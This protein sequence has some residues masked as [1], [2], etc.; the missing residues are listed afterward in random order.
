M[1]CY[2][3]KS[4]AWYELI[5]LNI[6]FPWK[7]ALFCYNQ[8][9]S[10]LSCS[11]SAF[12][13]YHYFLLY[14]YFY[15]RNTYSTALMLSLVRSVWHLDVFNLILKLHYSRELNVAGFNFVWELSGV[16]YHFY[17]S[18][19]MLQEGAWRRLID[20]DSSG[21][22]TFLDLWSSLKRC[23]SHSSLSSS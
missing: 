5:F 11:Q 17:S 6:F 22:E 18:T 15:F 13:F 1:Q 19:P 8:C 14:C 9:R 21:L 7:K 12:A 2:S 10:Q 23:P 4:M 20:A 16:S 3:S